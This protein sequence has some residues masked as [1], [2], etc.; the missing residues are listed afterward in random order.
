MRRL[1]C[2]SHIDRERAVASSQTYLVVILGL[3]SLQ[4][5]QFPFH[6]VSKTNSGCH[7]GGYARKR[8]SKSHNVA[9]GSTIAALLAGLSIR[10]FPTVLANSDGGQNCKKESVTARSPRGVLESRVF[11][12][13]SLVSD[14]SCERQRE[15]V[16]FFRGYG[17]RVSPTVCVRAVVN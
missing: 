16:Y 4:L 13:V 9:D 1:L 2:P 6:E 3:L 7:H 11:S 10:S 17:P 5:T 8:R 14:E 12:L 15:R